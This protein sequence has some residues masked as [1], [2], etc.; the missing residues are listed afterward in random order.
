MN[1]LIKSASTH[2]RPWCLI[3][4]SR[5]VHSRH[6]SR[7]QAEPDQT[8][9]DLK[10]ISKDL[11]NLSQ[12][13]YLDNAYLYGEYTD[14]KGKDALVAPNYFKV[15]QD[16]VNYVWLSTIPFISSSLCRVGFCLLGPKYGNFGSYVKKFM[17]LLN[18]KPK[19]NRSHLDFKA[20]KKISRDINKTDKPF[21]AFL[22]HFSFSHF[23][24]RHDEKCN[25]FNKD[26]VENE[27]NV[28]RQ[29]TCVLGLMKTL[30]EELKN[31]NL[32]DDS[33]IVFKSD[34]GKPFS[35]YSKSELRG[36]PIFSK[37]N[38]WGYDRYR[39][40]TMVK[41]PRKKGSKLTLNNDLFYLSDLNKIYC[42]SHEFF[43]ETSRYDCDSVNRK[44]L[45]DYDLQSSG[46][47]YLYIP[48]NSTNFKFDGHEA[49]KI[50][51][52]LETM[53]NLFRSWAIK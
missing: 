20:F 25:F 18:I 22:G 23:P 48:K 17:L 29:V 4:Q 34:H 11:I 30:L 8:E 41:L 14:F 1:S 37:E 10:L 51:N 47:K 26:L 27:T 46:E 45:N 31:K 12:H 33:L 28:A 43:F 13:W 3:F 44:L 5:V 6:Q 7:I 42:Q 32:Y 50:G 38:A 19:D 15:I 24:I 52:K 53:E 2:S 36:L 39:P 40:F 21:A 35:F 16:Q 9:S 49:I